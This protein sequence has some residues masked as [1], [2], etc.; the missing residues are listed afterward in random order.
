M[1]YGSRSSPSNSTAAA[2]RAPAS[3]PT[4]QE[5]DQLE[6]L[7]EGRR[8][9]TRRRSRWRS[10]PGP[11]ATT[12]GSLV[13][14]AEAALHAA[15]ASSGGPSSDGTPMASP[16]VDRGTG[17]VGAEPSRRRRMGWAGRGAVAAARSSDGF[18]ATSQPVRQVDVDVADGAAGE[19]LE[20]VRAVRPASPAG[21]HRCG[22]APNVMPPAV[23]GRE[24][25]RATVSSQ[26]QPDTVSRRMRM[27]DG[28]SPV[29]YVS[30]RASTVCSRGRRARPASGSGRRGPGRRLDWNR[31]SREP[32][33]W[34]RPSV[35]SA[36]YRPWCRRSRRVRPRSVAPGRGRRVGRA[37]DADVSC[38]RIAASA[39]A[40]LIG[41]VSIPGVAATGR[42]ARRRSLGEPGVASRGRG[43]SASP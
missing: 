3:E 43:G 31:P 21:R 1:T 36:R 42:P 40:Q 4:G 17:P 22:A 10:R 35:R 32:R 34:P 20:S 13:P 7:V 37:P 16:D 41:G 27:A 38:G 39:T 19:D 5:P 29:G 6:T 25:S 23:R 26:A 15:A 24:G 2:R 30:P 18:G 11:P 8:S 33:G 14:A 28:R 9:G 12:G